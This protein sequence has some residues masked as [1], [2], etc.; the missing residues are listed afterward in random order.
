MS[1]DQERSPDYGLLVL[2]D[3]EALRDHLDALNEAGT[4]DRAAG[5]DARGE[6]FLIALDGCYAETEVVL[7]G[8]PWNNEVDWGTGP[9]C[10]E[11]MAQRPH[12][13]DSLRF[14]VRILTRVTPTGSGD[15][16]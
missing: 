5:M 2:A 8:N 14:P 10:V 4:D 1:S 6:P 11:C 7:Y 9:S 15:T 12:R 13:L 3:A 16:P